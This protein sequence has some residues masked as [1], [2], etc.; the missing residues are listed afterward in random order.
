[1]KVLF[2]E[3]TAKEGMADDV[4]RLV[5]GLALKV[6]GEEGN[7][8]FEPYRELED[9][10]RFFVFE[11]YMDEESFQAHLSMPY[12]RPFNDAL[13]ELIEEPHSMLT[14]LEATENG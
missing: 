1:M 4:E 7:I 8:R 13:L 3:F 2:A 10:N 12:G 5:D 6:R 14:F 9:S 11:I